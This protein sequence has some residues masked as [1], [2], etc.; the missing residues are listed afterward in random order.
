[1]PPPNFALDAAVDSAD[2]SPC[3][4][5]RG[6]SIYRGDRIVSTGHN[7][8]VSP[9][10]CVG[11]DVCKRT[12]RTMAVH[13]EQFALLQAGKDAAGADLVHVKTVAGRLVP[14][15]GPSCVQCSKLMLPAGIL[16]VWLFH[17]NGWR[18]YGA[19]EFH[20]LSVDAHFGCVEGSASG[21]QSEAQK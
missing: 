1:M 10:E 20:R 14:S 3:R 2:L 8:Q 6:V 7:D 13:A 9:F 15:G 19:E 21:L 5:K 18:R 4:S 16:G 11:T 17:E 12:C